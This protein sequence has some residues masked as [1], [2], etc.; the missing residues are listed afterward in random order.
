MPHRPHPTEEVL[1]GSVVTAPVVLP[2][3]LEMGQAG[4]CMCHCLVHPG[5]TFKAPGEAAALA[6]APAFIQAERAWLAG[7]GLLDPAAACRPVAVEV[8]GRVVTGGRV[9]SG[10]TEAFFEPWHR[11]LDDAVLDLGLRVLAAARE[12]LMRLMRGLPPAMLDWRP[13]PGKR[14]LGEVL[15]HLANT[16][17]YYAVHLET[18]DRATGDLWK[19]AA[20]PGAP[21]WDRLDHARRYLVERL[22]GLSA[23]ERSRV[24]DHPSDE[25][26]IE[27]WSARKVLYRA[28]WHE[29]YHTRQMQGWL[30]Q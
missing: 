11:P 9:T 7:R 19:Q 6:L 28:I 18:P 5:A 16:E 2:V 25:D 26:R 21:V 24:T 12:D 15:E 1:G 10:D 4:G 22:R 17:A 13:A 27:R 20:L 29:R 3:Y 14:S 23:E 30:V 8:A